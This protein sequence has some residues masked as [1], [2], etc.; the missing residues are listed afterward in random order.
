MSHNPLTVCAGCGS[1]DIRPR[2]PAVECAACEGM[3]YWS[4][5]VVEFIG[6]RKIARAQAEYDAMGADL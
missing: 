4:G 2:G 3:S 5:E 6:Q 1:D